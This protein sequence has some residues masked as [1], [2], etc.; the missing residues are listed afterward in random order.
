VIGPSAP[1]RRRSRSRGGCLTALIAAAALAP[2][3]LAAC[4]PGA[5]AAPS[6]ALGSGQP[7]GLGPPV[8]LA[9]GAT[10]L[11]R[12]DTSL[13]GVL[14][15]EVDGLTVLESSEA[16]ADEQSNGSLASLSDGVVG[17]LAIDP[18]TSDFVL[19]HVA[20][21]RQGAFTDAIFRTW[22]DTFDAGTCGDLG[23]IGNAQSN[24][25]GRTVFVGTCG[26]GWHTYHAWIQDK[27]LLISASA[28][29]KRNLGQLLFES[30]RP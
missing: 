10:A 25:G 14:P 5:T 29:G 23:V 16:E 26:N 21:L 15:S 27:N 30:L 13:L 22:R 7:G 19:V 1:G 6:A 17:A 20:R 24:L 28:G 9:P 11:V 4:S 2:A 8:T 12:I 3:S 18:A